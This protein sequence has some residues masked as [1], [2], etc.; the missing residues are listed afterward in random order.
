MIQNLGKF[1]WISIIDL[2]NSYQQ[3]AIAAEDQHKVSFTWG[4]KQWMFITM[5]YGVKIMTGIE[6]RVMESLLGKLGQQPYQDDVPI[7]D[8]DTDEHVRRVKQVLEA[9]TYEAGLR[10]RIE[11]CKFFQTEEK[12]L[13]YWV[14]RDRI[15][16]D[17]KKTQTIQDWARPVDGKGVQ[18]F[19]GAVNYNRIFSAEFASICAPLEELRQAVGLIAW[20]EEQSQAFEQVKQLFAQDLT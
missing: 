3:F 20:S 5:P 8:T 10:I 17:P 2:Q 12:L 1:K 14:T 13:G 6:Q 9:L 11:K 4:G 16:M 18:R 7:V 15:S 19:L